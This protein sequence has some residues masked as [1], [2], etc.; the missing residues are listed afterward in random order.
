MKEKSPLISI[1][2]PSYNHQDYIE[3]CINSILSQTYTNFELII[4]DDCSTDKTAEIILNITDKKLNFFQNKFNKGMNS[5]LNEAFRHAHGDFITILGSDD[6]FEPHYLEEFVKFINLN[7]DDFTVFYPQI[8]PVDDDGK[9]LNNEFR[10]LEEPFPDNNNLLKNLF[11]H[12]NGLASPGM[13]INRKVAKKIFPLDCGIHQHQD[14]IMH[15]QL[16]LLGNCAFIPDAKTCYRVPTDSNGHMSSNCV[17]AY[18]RIEIETPFALNYFLK[19]IKTPEKLKDIFGEMITKY[20]EP[21]TET[22]PYFLA[23]L[24]LDSKDNRL[25]PVW[26]FRTLIEFLSTDNHQELLYKLYGFQYKDFSALFNNV[27]LLDDFLEVQ[28]NTFEN[29]LSWKITA[30]LRKIVLLLKKRKNK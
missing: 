20:G 8:I 2:I 19:N 21:T 30:P 12:G 1:L 29:S 6:F 27:Q 26:G 7:G 10:L 16:L 3:Q 5:S 24:A 9:I 25:L 23:R 11:L 4:V 13:I 22:I 17:K 18:K 28:K 14:F 15:I